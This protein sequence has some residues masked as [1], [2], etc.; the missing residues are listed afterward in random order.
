M[1]AQRETLVVGWANDGGRR[2][3]SFSGELD[4]ATAPLA[5][6]ALAEGA[7]VLDLS[8][9]EFMDSSGLKVLLRV[10][11]DRSE[12]LVVR[13]VRPSV[14]RLLDMTGVGDLLVFEETSSDRVG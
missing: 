8:E 6:R 5:E 14:R 11:S 10:C 4:I 2:I 3:L 1:S 13:G 12:R 9:L 7:D